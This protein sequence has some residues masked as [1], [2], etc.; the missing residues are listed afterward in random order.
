MQRRAKARGREFNA[1]DVVKELLMD[2][3]LQQFGAPPLATPPAYVSPTASKL[4]SNISARACVAIAARLIVHIPAAEMFAVLGESADNSIP[5]SRPDRRYIANDRRDVTGG[6][7]ALDI[8]LCA[9][10]EREVSSHT[11]AMS[12]P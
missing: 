1:D 5:Q 2:A 6:L 7:G 10:V 12:E 3:V 4:P 9:R 8:D 11:R